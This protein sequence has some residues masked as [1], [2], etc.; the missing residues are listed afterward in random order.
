[1]NTMK[2]PEFKLKI[3]YEFTKREKVLL[4]VLSLALLVMA[5]LFLVF[6]PGLRKYEALSTKRND[7]IFKQQQMQLAINSLQANRQVKVNTEAEIAAKKESYSQ[8]MNN[9]E[10][11]NMLTNLVVDQG[12]KAQ[13]L[14]INSNKI[15]A[16]PV[17]NANREEA[18]QTTQGDGTTTEAQDLANEEGTTT[19]TDNSATTT[20]TEKVEGV[21][22]GNVTM[23]IQG[24]IN[25]FEN[26]A[27]TINS[28]QDMQITLFEIVP[29]GDK[30]AKASASTIAN[31]ESGVNIVNVTFNVYMVDK[32]VAVTE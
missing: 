10:L 22:I 23:T 5:A 30:N 1:G 16:V 4:Y 20:P 25:A 18:D 19:T 11:D 17:F 29:K 7:A 32:P 26:L 9:D 28:R 24:T 15:S 14:T 31:V 12:F 2:K 27:D 6:F 3:H 13:D 8:K 21:Y